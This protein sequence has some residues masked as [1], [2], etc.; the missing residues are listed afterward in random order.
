[1]APVTMSFASGLYDRM[2][3]LATGEV[4]PKAL[5]LNFIDV[6]RDIFDRQAASKE[7]DASDMPTSEYITRYAAGDSSFIAVPAFPSR[8]FRHG[9]I[10]VN[11]NKVRQPKDLEG[12]T[13]GVQL[14]TTTAAVWQK[15]MF[16][17]EYGVNLDTIE[18]IEGKM[19]GPGSHGK[20]SALPPLKPVKITTNTKPK[21]LSQLLEDGD[22]DATVGADL[23]ECL[24]GAPHIK[25]LFPAFK[26]VEM[27]YYKETS[28][29]P[30]MHLVVLQTYPYEATDLR[31]HRSSKH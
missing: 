29:F 30:V 2:V 13:V 22:S 7:F 27:D 8:A 10:V 14:Y 31:H 3:P 28:I 18:W 12:E 24:G 11:S 1:M 5:D 15:G 23:P 25:R 21:S 16:Q 4:H 6:H 9:F 20:P 26:Q 17:H 19:E